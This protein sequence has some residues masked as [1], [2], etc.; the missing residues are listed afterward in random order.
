MAVRYCGD[1]E[2]RTDV[3]TGQVRVTLR[4][5]ARGRVRGVVYVER[6]PG[7][8]RPDPSGY[9]R[10]VRRAILDLLRDEPRLPV[11]RASFGGL[12]VRRV[13]QAPCPRSDV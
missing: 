11:E 8:A 9:D 5:P 13:F 12:V 1:V 4:W 3:R 10:I 6:W 2:A 7:R